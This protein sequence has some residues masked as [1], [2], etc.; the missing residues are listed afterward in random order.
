MNERTEEGIGGCVFAVLYRFVCFDSS[1]VDAIREAKRSSSF[2]EISLRVR[3][4]FKK[5]RQFDG[6]IQIDSFLIDDVRNNSAQ[7]VAPSP[8]DVPIKEQKRK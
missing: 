1:V 2:A 6:D 8:S 4:E 7:S 3:E 5:N